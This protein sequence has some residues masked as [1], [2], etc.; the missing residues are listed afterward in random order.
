SIG[1]LPDGSPF[2]VGGFAGNG[3]DRPYHWFNEVEVFSAN[4]QVWTVISQTKKTRAKGRSVVLTGGAVL[5][6]GGTSGTTPNIVTVPDA[7]LFIP[8]TQAWVKTDK[9]LT[10]RD[11]HT[12]TL[13]QNGLVLA[14]GGI[15]REGTGCQ[16]VGSSELYEPYRAGWSRT[17]DILTPRFYH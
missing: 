12:L 14:T 3:L 9:M 1:T 5:V 16:A 4:T 13:L 8:D 6:S 17:A 7:E 15:D 2:L 10:G 11:G